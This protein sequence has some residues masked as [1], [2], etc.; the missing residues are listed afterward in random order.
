MILK[1]RLI[2]VPLMVLAALAVFAG[3]GSSSDSGSTE[4][5]STESSGVTESTE[6][7]SGGSD[8]IVKAKELAAGYEETKGIKFPEP[9]ESFDPGAGKVAV[10]TC[11]N[12]GINCL[13]GGEEAVVAAKAMGWG[14]SS[15]LD[16][17]FTPA[18]QAGYVQQAVQEGY[19]GIVLVSIDAQSIKSAV[20]AAA[21]KG[22]PIACVMCVN[23]AF[24][25]K[26]V[27]T[28]SGGIAEGK[29]LGDWVAANSGGDAAVLA[30]GDEA[31][32]IVAV[33][34]ENA[35][36]Q[37]EELCPGCTIE[38][39]EF[40]TA[41]LAKPGS[42]TFEAALTSNPPGTLD[43]VMAPYDPAAIPM[44]KAAQ[45]QGREDFKLTGYDASPEW[46]EMIAEGGIA[47][48]TTASPFPYASWA[49]VD[50]VGRMHAGLEPWDAGL[51]PTALVTQKNASE[52]V[53]TGGFLKPP[54]FDFE[55]LFL[56][57][58]GKK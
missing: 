18:K 36:E 2:G 30:Y 44:A 35:E 52:F 24:K 27:D 28:T 11:G 14:A 19:D 55:A 54:D 17:E 45:Q 53:K 56:E 7:E 50:E 1:L 16:G 40:P 9:T 20:D 34:R 42:P 23:P 31:F 49:A 3:C 33:R 22:V 43:F 57:L 5:S 8:G 12:A 38:E 39:S 13:K 10:I 41:D 46:V 15:V 21:A 51:M 4:S 47:G 29:A 26:V 6:A 58:W 37:I 48:A 32:P 25:G